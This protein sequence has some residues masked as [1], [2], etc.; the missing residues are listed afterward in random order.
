MCFSSC[1]DTH[2]HASVFSVS[3]QLSSILRGNTFVFHVLQGEHLSA[4]PWH[5][6]SCVS[7]EAHLLRVCVLLSPACVCV[8]AYADCSA[9]ICFL[10]G[11]PA[12]DMEDASVAPGS[13]DVCT[14]AA[15]M[16]TLN[17]AGS[18]QVPC[19]RCSYGLV[20]SCYWLPARLKAGER[21][22]K[23]TWVCVWCA[24]ALAVGFFF[25]RLPGLINTRSQR[26]ILLT[27]MF[28]LDACMMQPWGWMRDGGTFL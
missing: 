6:P 21:L 5:S 27:A 12:F 4:Q 3:L 2:K 19:C 24:T 25:Y 28:C 18:R 26:E 23:D 1:T 14:N 15:R 11:R 13:A 16:F 8:C 22:I 9:F 20:S 7:N 10:Y 17:H